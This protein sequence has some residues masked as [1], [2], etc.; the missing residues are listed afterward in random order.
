MREG[1]KVD[2]K[3]NEADDWI[4]KCEQ[5]RIDNLDDII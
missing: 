1:T 5:F 2:E 4:R 3:K